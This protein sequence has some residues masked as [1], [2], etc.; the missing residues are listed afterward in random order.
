MFTP[1]PT[2]D[3][4]KN[5]GQN[6]PQNMQQNVAQNTQ[7]PRS[8]KEQIMEIVEAIMKKYNLKQ[9]VRRGQTKEG[10]LET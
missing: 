2:Q 6:T 7:K 4:P 5:V 1:T 9:A 8:A 10:V 3:V